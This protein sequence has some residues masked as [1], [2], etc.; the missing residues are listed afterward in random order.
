MEMEDLLQVSWFYDLG[1]NFHH[2]NFHTLLLV[3]DQKPLNI[4]QELVPFLEK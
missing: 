2:A 3:Q 1:C 4:S